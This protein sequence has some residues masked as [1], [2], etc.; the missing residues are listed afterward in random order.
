LI[1]KSRN[2]NFVWTYVLTWRAVVV[3]RRSCV[4]E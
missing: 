2:I 4:L 3:P 1:D